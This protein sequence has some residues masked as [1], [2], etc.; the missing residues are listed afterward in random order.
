[1]K[2]TKIIFI[3]I[4]S[5]LASC[6]FKPINEKNSSLIYFNDIVVSGDKRISYNLKNNILLISDDSSKNNYDA[7]IKLTKQ[8]KTKIKDISGK[9]TRYNVNLSALLKLT[10]NKNKKEIQKTFSKNVDYDVAKIH[11]NTINNENNATKNLT[12]QIST[13]IINFISLAMRNK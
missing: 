2:N 6:G 3:L 5:L 10:N 13:D 9:V 11:S 4:F 7:E 12:Q 8:K 1:M